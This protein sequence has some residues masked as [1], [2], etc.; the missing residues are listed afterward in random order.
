[1][2]EADQIITQARTW[3]GT[4]FVHQGRSKKTSTASGGVDCIGLIIGVAGELDI[5][6]KDGITPLVQYDQVNY[7]RSPDGETLKKELDAH[8]IAVELDDIRVADILLTRIVES[9]QHVG[10][11]GD[12]VHGGLS[13]IHAYQ[14]ENKVVEHRLDALWM[15]RV[16]AAYRFYDASLGV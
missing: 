11:V 7:S 1:M 5:K 6:A 9:P 15:R 12:Y 2:I 4:S 13:F 3:L 10:F 8:F 16:V 14:T